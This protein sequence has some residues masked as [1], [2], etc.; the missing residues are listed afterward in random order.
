[1]L[2]CVGPLD[3]KTEPAEITWGAQG[4]LKGRVPPPSRLSRLVRRTRS[5]TFQEP[6][7]LR[8]W[9]PPP[10]RP[11][12]HA[13]H[14]PNDSNS[15][16]PWP[17]G[18]SIARLRIHRSSD[19]TA[20]RSLPGAPHAPRTAET[21]HTRAFTSTHS[22]TIYLATP[23]THARPRRSHGVFIPNSILPYTPSFFVK[24][25]RSSIY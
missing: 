1:L 13:H 2:L 12:P 15:T 19:S 21:R 14:S 5:S 23:C 3:D 16:R 18:C 9:R 17:H 8:T 7:A 10:A 20:P 22:R 24:I 11:A 6:F 25:E 4:L